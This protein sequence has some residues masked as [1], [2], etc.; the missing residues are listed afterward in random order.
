MTVADVCLSW[1][2]CILFCAFFLFVCL[3]LLSLK[4]LQLS[5]A[6]LGI[7]HLKPHHKLDFC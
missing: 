3:F 5:D 1:P 2:L 4:R 6:E 7:F